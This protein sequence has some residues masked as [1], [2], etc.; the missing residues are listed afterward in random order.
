MRLGVSIVLSLLCL[1]G[2]GLAGDWHVAGSLECGDCHLQHGSNQRDPTVEGAFSFLLRKNSVNELCMSCHDGTDPTAPDVIAPAPMYSSTP[3][4]ESAAGAF[5][6]LGVANP[7]GHSISV[8][9][10]T[11]LQQ[12]PLLRELN[13]VS[14]HSAH[15]NG[16]YRNLLTDPAGTGASLQIEQ[17]VSVFIGAQPDDPPSSAG[18]IAAYSRDNVGYV[19]GMSTWCSSCHDQLGS[20]SYASAPAHF[21]SHP[22][23]IALNAYPYDDHTD[24][25][26]WVAGNGEGFAP[27]GQSPATPR[28]P[29]L[30]TGATD[31][32]TSRT[33]AAHNR[34]SC[35]SCH[36]AHGS[37][38]RKGMAW[39]YLEE[40]DNALS[41]CQQCHNK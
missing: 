22:S 39:P 2:L 1:P 30:A 8:E 40:N 23:D 31:F 26:H 33:A 6:A 24:P 7:N 10:P 38:Y 18:S 41:G 20:N 19:S 34:V 14:C 37:S 4:E 36:K 27:I 5:A 25:T 17:G 35:V 32:R 16:N 13:C 9:L 21:N 12:V 11:P 3:S 29:F 15:G 28:V